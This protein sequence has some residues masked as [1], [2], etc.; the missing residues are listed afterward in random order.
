MIES[1]VI[2]DFASYRGEP[3]VIAGLAQ[4]NYFYG[5]NGSGK[6]TIGKIIDDDPA[7]PET[8]R[9]IW[10]DGRELEAKVY[11]RDFVTRNFGSSE[12]LKGVFTLGEDSLETKSKIVEAKK[13]E[14]EL[15]RA[16]V[17]QSANLE[18]HL[19][20]LTGV[21]H[22]L[23][24]ACWAQK[25]KY[26]D[27][28]KP[29][30][31]GFL[32]SKEQFKQQI[33]TRR[34][35]IATLQ[36]LDVLTRKALTVFGE[37][38]ERETEVPPLSCSELVAHETD[39]LLTTR[40]VGKEDVNV[41]A[42]IH[43]LG[44]S[45]W[46]RT[47]REYLQG[48][49]GLCPFCQQDV[50]AGLE[51][52]L[53]DYFDETFTQ[54]THSFSEFADNYERDAQGVQERVEQLLVASNRFL[55][56][57][58]LKSERDALDAKVAINHERLAAKRS[59]PSTSMKLVSL[60]GVLGTIQGLINAANDNTREHNQTVDN[61]Q[62]ECDTL[63]VQVWKYLVETELK[64]ALETYDTRKKSITAAADG[65]RAAI[66]E[67]E[68]Q[69]KALQDEIRALEETTTSIQ[70][71]VGGINSLL[72]NLGFRGFSIDTAEDGAS[73][74]LIREDGTEVEDTLSEGERSFVT[75]LYF[76]YLLRGSH[77]ASGTAKDQIVV[78]DDPV[79][80]LDSDTLF[81]VSSLIRAICDEAG[82]GAGNIKQCFVLTH[83]V[84]FHHEVT[85]GVES[86]K[87]SRSFWLVRKPDAVSKVE[88]RSSNPVKTSYHLLWEE[89]RRPDCTD[90]TV[91]NAMRRILEHYFK[92]L[93]GLKSLDDLLADFKGEEQLVCRSL[94]SWVHDGSHSI[95]EDMYVC[96]GDSCVEMYLRVF[97]TIFDKRNQLGHYEMM[98]LES[99]RAM[100]GE[101][102]GG[103]Q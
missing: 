76:Y 84:H 13:R 32:G 6:S 69:R 90:V 62:V 27:T 94:I 44:N 103:S 12:N 40:I 98:W 38:P 7:V 28:F 60:A 83:N 78:F 53:N 70:P 17:H 55:D 97:K 89:I 77:T 93:G 59:Q 5:S 18:K 46:V 35:S 20:Q 67:N 79:S 80:S 34:S 19:G 72:A 1:I 82:S 21:E 41:A 52:D 15:D 47:G 102:V 50:P 86:A 99:G 22:D 73:Y 4:R 10:Q 49:E 29:A 9:V 61:L 100:L 88:R 65:I 81:V 16:L 23:T 91:Q 31:A 51:Q 64:L 101:G 25:V 39:P 48:S 74:V 36:T 75:F 24:E 2:G 54:Q 8:C 30:F 57:K 58:T 14:G 87:G 45:D 33:L 71:T 3:S 37:A 96:V 43:K 95:H 26:E 85:H 92:T 56:A 11:N 42:L 66:E 68:K 63:K